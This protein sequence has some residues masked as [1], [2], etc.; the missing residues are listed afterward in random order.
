MRVKT[1][2][3]QA[4]DRLSLRLIGAGGI[5]VSVADDGMEAEATIRLAQKSGVT[6]FVNADSGLNTN[7]GRTWDT[8]FLTMAAAFA[9]I[10]SGG[11]IF[12]HGKVREQLTCPVEVFDVSVIGAGNRPRHIDGT[13]KAGSQSAAMWTTNATPATTTPLVKVIQQGWQFVN[14]LFA[15]PSAAACVQLFRDAGSGDDERDGSHTEFVNCRFASGQHGIEQSGG[16]HE[17]GIF[18]CRFNDLTGFAIK[19]TTGAGQGYPHSWEIRDSRFQDN[20]NVLKMACTGWVVTGNAFLN[21]TT[22]IF[23]TDAGDA[24]AGKNIVVGN[25][26]NVAAAGFGP[27]QNVEGNSTDVW[28]NYLVDGIESKQPDG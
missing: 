17:N 12:F 2:T 5:N 3:T 6:Y 8:A 22:E 4:E 19:D 23:D 11:T 1:S 10:D 26:F 28:S 7:D 15:G 25:Y 13:P 9:V 21:T 27:T 16:C 20:V 24:T 14:I 18:H